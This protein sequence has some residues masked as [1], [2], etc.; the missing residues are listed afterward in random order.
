MAYKYLSGTLGLVFRGEDVAGDDAAVFTQ[1][2]K[3][4]MSG[5]HEECDWKA[6]EIGGFYCWI[7]R[8]RYAGI[9]PIIRTDYGE[10]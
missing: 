6:L 10:L 4:I 9:Y 7:H 8:T 2:G 1:D 5:H 3:F